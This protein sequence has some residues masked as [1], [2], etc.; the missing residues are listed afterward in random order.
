[1]HDRGMLKKWNDERGFGFIE[2]AGTGEEIFVHMSEFPKGVRPEVGMFVSFTTVIKDGKQRAVGVGIPGQ[3]PR[4]YHRVPREAESARSVFVFLVPFVIVLVL[5]IAAYRV[6]GSLY[7]EMNPT[8]K[9]RRDRAGA[10]IPMRPAQT[11]LPDAILR[12]GRLLPRPLPGRHD[13]W[14][15]RPDALRGATLLLREHARWKD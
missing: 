6:V 5:G 3:A 2:V 13:G 1:M 7:W 4:K 11:L 12:R 8:A 9:A 10:G 15:Q 14:G